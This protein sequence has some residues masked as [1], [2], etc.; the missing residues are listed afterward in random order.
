MI[1]RL[2][3]SGAALV[4]AIALLPFVAGCDKK[5]DPVVIVEDDTPPFPPDGVFSVTGDEVVSI[6]WNANWEDD[7]AG[8]A[9]FRNDQADG[10]YTH[11]S[12][13]PVDQT[14]YDDTDVNNG[15]TWYY[16]VL[17]FD[18]AGNESDLSYELVFDTPRPAGYD[19][20][21][22]DFTGQNSG[23]SGYDFSSV[24]GTAEPQADGSTD[25]Y[26]GVQAGVNTIFTNAGASIQDYGLI[27]LDGV[28]WAPESGWAPSGHAE[29]IIG[30]SYVIRIVG[31]QGRN[32][33]KVFVK[34]VSAASVTLDWAY[35]QSLNNPELVPPAGGASR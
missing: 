28:D 31:S 1:Y 18:N 14:Y 13:V 24:S 9:V 26:F 16:A 25:I 7:L 2:R 17:A 6:Y 34:D 35:Q 27:D 19:L 23:L 15:E 12:D 3:L 29:A 30:H 21:L 8:Y 11:V 4:I 33:A 20:V 32:Y 22:F 10:Y 5:E